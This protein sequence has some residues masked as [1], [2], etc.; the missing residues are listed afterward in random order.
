MTHHAS[1]ARIN[2][3]DRIGY[4]LD[5]QAGQDC[6]VPDRRRRNRTDLSDHR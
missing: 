2:A 1:A 6:V 5:V 3:F 4:L